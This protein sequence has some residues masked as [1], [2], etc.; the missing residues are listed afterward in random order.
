MTKTNFETG[1]LPDN[2]NYIHLFRPHI[3]KN[4]SKYLNEVL[5]SRWIGQGP[6][7]EEFEDKISSKF[8]SN[9]PGIAVGSG[10]DA[11]HLAYLLAGVKAGDEVIV[12]LFTCTATSIPLLYIGAKPVFIDIDPESLN[13]DVNLIEAA[14]TSKTK[15]IVVV[16]YGGLPVDMDAVKKIADKFGL[17]VI[18]DAAH[19]LGAS[20]KNKLIGSISDLTIFS[21]QA[22]KHLTTGD[23][24]YLSIRNPDI[25]EKAKR[26]RWFG[27]DRT[28]KQNGIWENDIT[29]IGFKYQMT[30]LAAAIGLAGMEEFDETLEFRKL[31]FNKYQKNL[32]SHH[33]IKILND[34]IHS[35]RKH[36]S[37]MFT[38]SSKNRREIQQKL[39]ENNI[40]SNQVHY[41][42]DRY[43]IFK[44]SRGVFPAMDSLEDEYLVLP[45]HTKMDVNDVDRVCEIIS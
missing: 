42:N 40:E 28:A 24:G 34:D 43:T 23:G 25:L 16:H 3:P 4:A 33:D 37:W 2:K 20:Y 44:E 22:I 21:F 39:F 17:I 36:A 32:D 19:A 45:L 8:C 35:D 12:P 10:T 30:D 26:L 1:L 15:A 9:L 13:L 11:L 41:R 7:V 6:R 5:S 18:E 27:I 29:E 31:L 14:I 38:I